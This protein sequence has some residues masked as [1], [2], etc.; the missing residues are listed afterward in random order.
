MAPLETGSDNF[1]SMARK[2]I[3]RWIPDAATFK[4]RPGLRFLGVLLHD[5][6]LF[7][8]NRHS[9]SVAVFVGIF[10]AFLP[11]F[12]QTPVAAM[13][14]LIFRCNLPIAVLLV[15]ISNPITIP[16]IFYAT[17]EIGRW[18]LDKP[19]VDFSIELTW[20]WFN[21]EFLQIWKPLLTGSLMCGIL[22]GALGYL[23]MQA[24]WYWT[25]MRNWEKRRRARQ[26]NR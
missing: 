9:V 5:P 26:N 24:F 23:C 6:N 14:A 22:F 18:V 2:F 3:K 16:P 21:N 1:Y 4:E 12:G 13:L 20:T 25:V 11:F 7:H 17:Y 8:L 15:W 10:S 19:E